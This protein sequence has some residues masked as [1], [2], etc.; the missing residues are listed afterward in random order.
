MALMC[1]ILCFA[2]AFSFIER[3]RE[4]EREILIVFSIGYALVDEHVLE[5]QSNRNRIS[6]YI[7]HVCTGEVE[8]FF[9]YHLIILSS[10]RP[11]CFECGCGV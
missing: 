9:D 5:E 6:V 11:C 2:V 4:R 3:E 7:Q 8:M 1:S 10:S